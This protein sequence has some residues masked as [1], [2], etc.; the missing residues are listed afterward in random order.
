M[1]LKQALIESAQSVIHDPR[2]PV[3]N[4]TE[5]DRIVVEVTILSKPEI[6]KSM[7]HKDILSQIL[8]GRDGLIIEQGFFK[9]LLLPQVPIEQH[10]DSKTFIEQTCVK[11]GLSHNVWLEEETIVKS[12][13][14][15]IFSEEKPFG[16]VKEKTFDES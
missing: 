3:L 15:Q 9:G 8:V 13:T 14:G 5:L 12:F 6:I 10:W 7:G 1:H 2:F 4:V 11:A 16:A